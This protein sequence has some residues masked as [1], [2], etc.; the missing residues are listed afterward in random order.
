MNEEKNQKVLAVVLSI[1]VIGLGV[2]KFFFSGNKQKEKIDT[3]TIAS[4]TNVDDF[5]TV[6]SC[7]DKYIAYSTSNDK[8]KILILLSDEYKKQNNVTADNLYSFV[9]KYDEYYS[10]APKEMYVQKKSKDISKY[11][12]Y[13][14]LEKGIEDTTKT[15]DDFYLIVILDESN[16]T[17]SIEPYDGEMFK[18]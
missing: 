4:V 13:G 5:Y 2:Y 16:L 10:F 18:K 6:A 8:N 9:E 1:L 7:V 15:Y 11:Y 14:T 17:F 3:K 12:V